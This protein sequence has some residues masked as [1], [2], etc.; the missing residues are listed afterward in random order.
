MRIFRTYK[1]LIKPTSIQK[2][3][4]RK[5]LEVCTLVYNKYIE[6]DG[7]TLYKGKMA[8]EILDKYRKE[9]DVINRVDTSAVINL[10]FRL[11]DNHFKSEIVKPKNGILRSYTT[12]NLRGLGSF[13]FV[14][15]EYINFP[16]LGNVKIVYY[17][18]LPENAHI[19]SGTI[20]VDRGGK[21][22]LCLLFYIE[23]SNNIQSL[24]INNSIGLDYSSKNLFVDSEGNANG[25]LRPY[26]KMEQKINYLKDKKSKCAIGS[27]K[28]YD[29]ENKI[30]KLFRHCKNQRLDYLHKLS[31]SMANKYDIIC[32]EN[33]NIEKI[34]QGHKLGKRTYDNAY[35]TFLELLEYKMEDR[36]KKMIKVD[37]FYPSSKIC[38]VCGYK[39]EDLELNDRNWCCPNCKTMHER[40]I[41]AAINIKKKGI[42]EFISIGYLDNAYNQ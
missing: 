4:I 20:T 5:T 31:T 3:K 14:L 10:L 17:R 23:S 6:E 29:I 33:L 24:D 32:V 7:K 8:K 36:G 35:G 11:Q 30:N 22:F 40:D 34:S 12:S 16:K 9:E 13:Y 1:Y 21:Y 38:N 18:E 26:E 25:S 19:T 2:E 41:N 28:Y 39:K 37:R 27:R 15:D 42:E